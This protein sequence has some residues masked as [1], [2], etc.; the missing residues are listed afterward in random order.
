MAS[1]VSESLRR[2]VAERARHRCEYCLLPRRFP[3]ID[4]SRT[5]LSLASMR[6]PPSRPIWHWRVCTVIAKRGP[7]LA[8]SIRLRRH[9]SRCSTR[10]YRNGARISSGTE[11]LCAR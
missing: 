2:L 3:F 10:E 7:T 11:L 9:L 4:T 8:R 6:E 1:D 5:I